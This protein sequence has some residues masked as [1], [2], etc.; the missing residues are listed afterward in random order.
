VAGKENVVADALSRPATVVAVPAADQ[1]DFAVLAEQQVL[2]EDTLSV[3]SN[4]KLDVKS[5][6]V[7]GYEVLFIRALVPEMLRKNVFQSHP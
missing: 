6:N 3:D 2:C 1:L 5:V 7:Q 4:D